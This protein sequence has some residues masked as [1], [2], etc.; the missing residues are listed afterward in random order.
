MVV[1]NLEIVTPSKITYSGEI[2]SITV[3]G[4]LGSFQV[5][6]N[7]APLISTFEV[8][9]IKIQEK[10][11]TKYFATGGGTIEVLDNKV[12]ILADSFETPENIDVDRAKN[13]MNRAKER[14]ANRTE[15]VDVA[16]AEA[17]LQR[18]MN[19]LSV[20]DKYAGINI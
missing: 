18:A 13:A 11:Q 17:A 19:R 16:R 14:L 7:H 10:D 3:P 9:L 4:T 1:L 20:V 12:L 2:E 6:K 15:N 5:L 8:G